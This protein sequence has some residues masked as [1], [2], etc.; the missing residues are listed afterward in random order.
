[1]GSK[2]ALRLM[3]EMFVKVLQSVIGCYLHKST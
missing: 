3:G 2:V 1:M